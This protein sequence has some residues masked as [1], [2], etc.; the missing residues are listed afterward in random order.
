MKFSLM[1]AGKRAVLIA[2]LCGMM[3]SSYLHDQ[4]TVDLSFG[5]PPG[6]FMEGVLTALTVGVGGFAILMVF[7]LMSRLGP[8]P[9]ENDKD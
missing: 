1:G 3:A 4:N 2:V 8:R 7:R 5:F 6:G 9:D